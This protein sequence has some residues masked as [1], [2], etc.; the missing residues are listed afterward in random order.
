MYFVAFLAATILSEQ[1]LAPLWVEPKDIASRD[2][3]R[4]VGGPAHA[5]QDG[6]TFRFDSLETKGHSKGYYVFGVDGRKWKVKTGDEAASEV[7]ASRLLWA[8]GY[9]QPALYYLRDWRMSGGPETPTRPGRF[10]LISD[11]KSGDGW[12]FDDNPFVGSRELNGLVAANV[13]LNNW[14]LAASNNRIYDVGS[15]KRY[16]VQDLGAALGKTRWPIGS[17]NDIDDFESQDFVLGT[18]DGRVLFDYHARRTRLLRAIAPSDVVWVC[19]LLAKLS[20]RQLQDAFRGAGY[21]EELTGRYVRKIKG[22]IRQG[23]ALR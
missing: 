2:L 11:H 9:H 6:E 14:D 23:L 1:Q 4:G 18:E 10:R 19:G 22:K 5:P 21:S 17:R 16:V 15:E 7:A 3:L 8:I 13:L 20:D 12:A